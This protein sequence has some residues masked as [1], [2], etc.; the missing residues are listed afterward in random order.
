MFRKYISVEGC[1][2]GADFYLKANEK[3][4]KT[5]QRIVF[6]LVV[7]FIAA[8]CALYAI[9]ST[10]QT[11]EELEKVNNEFAEVQ[12][13][14]QISVENAVSKID[15]A[16]SANEISQTE[17]IQNHDDNKTDLDCKPDSANCQVEATSVAVNLENEIKLQDDKLN[18]N[19]KILKELAP[20]EK[21]K[22]ALKEQRLW[23]KERETCITQEC[24]LDKYQKRNAEI[25]VQIVDV[26]R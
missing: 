25:E 11:G 2:N 26:Q 15:T 23:L 10:S 4:K 18:Q 20:T 7:T 13:Q 21:Y 9:V 6:V 22:E 16:S 12:S 14:E 19:W 3:I 8:I 17:I 5:S 24:T 1:S